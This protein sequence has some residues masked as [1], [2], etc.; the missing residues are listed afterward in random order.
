MSQK[1]HFMFDIGPVKNTPCLKSIN[2]KQ[3]KLDYKGSWAPFYLISTD[4]SIIYSPKIY[5]RKVQSN[6]YELFKNYYITCNHYDKG[7]I[8]S[9]NADYVFLCVVGG[10][11]AGTLPDAMFCNVYFLYIFMN[12]KRYAMHKRRYVLF[13][14]P[15]S[16][17][18]LIFI[19]KESPNISE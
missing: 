2:V 5:N 15:M 19:F 12:R 18:A 10:G 8:A 1:S 7:W 4:S 3:I 13:K 16:I 6:I 11:G 17:V 9:G 14:N